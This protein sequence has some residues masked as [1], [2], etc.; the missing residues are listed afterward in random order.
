MQNTVPAEDRYRSSIGVTS[1][2]VDVSTIP[3]PENKSLNKEPNLQVEFP[4]IA[5]RPPAWLREIRY[6]RTVVSYCF[7][8]VRYSTE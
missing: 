2:A 5:P 7:H 8:K 6:I 1:M 3:M 4:Q